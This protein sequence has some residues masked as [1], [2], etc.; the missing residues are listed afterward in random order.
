MTSALFCPQYHD[1]G[2]TFT[3]D[4]KPQLIPGRHSKTCLPTLLCVCGGGGGA[5]YL[6][7]RHVALTF[8]N[9][10]K[11]FDHRGRRNST[12]IQIQIMF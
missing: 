8:T 5:S 2:E 1:W 3:Q 10:S 12:N 11:A 7:T 4:T 6:A 9:N